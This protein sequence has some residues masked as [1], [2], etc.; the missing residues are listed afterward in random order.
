MDARGGTKRGQTARES[1]GM[2]GQDGVAGR[3]VRGTHAPS[4]KHSPARGG[5]KSQKQVPT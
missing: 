3:Y 2:S 1:A 4:T 5:N